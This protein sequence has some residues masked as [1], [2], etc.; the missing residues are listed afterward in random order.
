MAASEDGKMT[1]RSV[2]YIVDSAGRKVAAVVDIDQFRSLIEAAHRAGAGEPIELES[3]ELR[4]MRYDFT[5]LIGRL[6]WNGDALSEQR[7]LRDE[8]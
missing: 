1:A 5:D 2:Q 4:S 8:W 6:Q 3:D 7:R